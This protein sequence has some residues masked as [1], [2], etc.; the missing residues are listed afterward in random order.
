[1]NNPFEP[2]PT[3]VPEE[4]DEEEPGGEV[5]AATDEEAEE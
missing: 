4:S 2:A 5:E 3:P 1:M